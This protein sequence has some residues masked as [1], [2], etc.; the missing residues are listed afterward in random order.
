MTEPNPQLDIELAV[1]RL[2][3]QARAK[4]DIDIG[5]IEGLVTD[6]A[7]SHQGDPR[8]AARH[9]SARLLVAVRMAALLTEQIE[10]SYT[11]M[12]PGSDLWADLEHVIRLRH[13]DGA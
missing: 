10:M 12:A 4:A 8:G 9:V 13:G 11:P 6:A 2:I 3:R 5:S 1:L 7:N